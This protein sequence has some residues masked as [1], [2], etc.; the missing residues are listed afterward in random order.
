MGTAPG[1]LEEGTV[2]TPPRLCL[3]GGKL[4]QSCHF[5]A[6]A[7]AQ[8]AISGKAERGRGHLAGKGQPCTQAAPKGGQAAQGHRDE[9][10]TMQ[11]WARAEKH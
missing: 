2:G 4:F 6:P 9:A 7:L 5:S 3:H 8:G 10:G 1:L 11:Q